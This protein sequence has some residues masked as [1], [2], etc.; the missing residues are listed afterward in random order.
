VRKVRP[1]VD[2]VSPTVQVAS[3]FKRSE[4][5]TSIT[6]GAASAL[7]DDGECPVDAKGR[8]HRYRVNVP[9]GW[10]EHAV[11]LEALGEQ[12]GNR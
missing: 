12:S 9:A 7:N 6:F 3:R 10:T 2:G 4:P 11:G 8:Y 5:E 1:L